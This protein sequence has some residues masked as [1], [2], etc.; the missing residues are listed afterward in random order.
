MTFV[1]SDLDGTY[2]LKLIRNRW[3]PP[4]KRL[5]CSSIDEEP[6]PN[7]SPEFWYLSHL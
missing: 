6:A 5:S 3:P 1:F 4:R 7:T 2:E